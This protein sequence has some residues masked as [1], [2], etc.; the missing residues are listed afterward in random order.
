M[1]AI[2]RRE[3]I[4]SAAATALTGCRKREPVKPSPVLIARAAYSQDLY[5]VVQRMLAELRLDVRGARVVLK[6]NLVEFDERTT[7]NTH[8]VVVHAVL[9]ALLALGAKEVRIAEGPGHRRN[10]WE[11][12]EAAGYFE[13]VPQFEARFTDLNVDEVVPVTLDRPRSKLRR[14]YL[15]RTVLDCDWL[16]SLP[17]MKTHHW[18]GATL[19]M[20]N[21]FGVVPGAIYGWPKNLLHWSGIAE[22][23]ADLHRLFTGGQKRPRL[24]ALV[25]GVV[26]MEG[27]GPIHGVP[28]PVGALVAGYDLVAVDAACCRIMRIEPRKIPYLLLEARPGALEPEAI[29]EIG[30]PIRA[31]ETPFELIPQF[32]SLRL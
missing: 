16:V 21:L 22:C 18:V 26:G 23:I 32:R 20:K 4:S 25:D 10:T 24:F 2:T 7:I 31:F 19:S 29:Q 28:K 6:P 5:D 8:P 15:P 11:L 13:T 3:W 30:E 9:E 12:A 14:L 1:K 27:D 17:K